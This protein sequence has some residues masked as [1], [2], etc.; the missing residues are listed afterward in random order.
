[1]N[2]NHDMAEALQPG[3]SHEFR[4]DRK[5]A[6]LS[7]ACTVP[8]KIAVA[9][10]GCDPLVEYSDSLTWLLPDAYHGK[11]VLSVTVTNFA[12]SKESDVEVLS[13]DCHVNVATEE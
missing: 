7:I 4:I 1:M 12:V 13:A 3:H 5:C 6:Y 8:I 2:T 11:R 9:F 10:V